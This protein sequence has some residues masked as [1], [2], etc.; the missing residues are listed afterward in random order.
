MPDLDKC[1]NC[2]GP[3]TNG[4]C[5]DCGTLIAKTA[6][7]E[8]MEDR[9]EELIDTETSSLDDI[10]PPTLSSI[11][12]DE[13]ISPEKALEISK[14]A[15]KPADIKRDEP[16]NPYANMIH[17]ESP[18]YGDNYVPPTTIIRKDGVPQAL[19]DSEIP[20]YDRKIRLKSDKSW[21]GYWWLILIIFFLPLRVGQ[22]NY[23][24]LAIGAGLLKFDE[25]GGRQAGAIIIG[26]C[27]LKLI[28]GILTSY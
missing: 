19:Q 23:I 3:I 16:S 15:E 20:E 8:A 12:G 9:L 24:G 10:V 4:L 18:D 1:P 26:I 13:V 5:L 25:K 28:L 7:K 22:L 17:Y 2:G 14:E 21:L 27:V 11:S 6:P